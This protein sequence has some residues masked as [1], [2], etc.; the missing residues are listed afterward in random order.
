[1]AEAKMSQAPSQLRNLFA[2]LIAHCNISNP[3]RLWENY[4]ES[5]AEDF[6]YEMQQRNLGLPIVF[7]DLIQNRVLILIEDKFLL[8]TRKSLQ[9]LGLPAP[10]RPYLKKLSEK[11]HMTKGI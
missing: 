3:L 6:I 5:M 10:Q 11:P 8:Y 4:K 2:L 1:M 7:S 9:D